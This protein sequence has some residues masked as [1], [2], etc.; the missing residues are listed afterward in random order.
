[1]TDLVTLSDFHLLR[2]WWLLTL[3]PVA[4]TSWYL[5]KVQSPTAKWRP[6]I[7]DHILEHILLPRGR[8]SWFNPVGVY[9]AGLVL[10]IIALSGP[11][12]E[13]QPAPFEED[14]AALVVVLDVSS[15]M[16]LT[17][18]SPT[19]LKRA[20][21][22]VADLVGL[23]GNARTALVVFSG[24]AH[25]AVPLTNDPSLF[26]I[27]L[28]A[29]GSDIMPVEGKVAQNAL[30]LA[31]GLLEKTD[32]SGSILLVTDD[33]PGSLKL[34]VTDRALSHQLLVLG[35]GA[36]VNAGNDKAFVPLNE[37][38]LKRLA[39]TNKGLYQRW[40]MD[41]T[42]IRTIDRRI[43]SHFENSALFVQP[44]VDMGYWLLYPAA[45]LLLLWFRKGWTLQW[46]IAGVV[47]LGLFGG[48]PAEAK[49]FR[50]I[51]LWMTPDQQG[52]H[53][54][55]DGDYSEAAARF[56]NVEW[57][58]LS[59]Y[60][61]EDFETAAELYGRLGTPEGFFSQANALARSQHYLRAVA[62][63]DEAL[64]LDP[65]LEKARHNRQIIQAIIDEINAV[66]AAQVPEPGERSIELGADDP[67]RAEGADRE[68]F[69][70]EEARQI[71]AEELLADEK[72]KEL[73]LRD[74]QSD[75]RRFLSAKFRIQLE[76]QKAATADTEGEE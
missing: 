10:G 71:S 8:F 5:V 76:Q 30:D 24:T 54:F 9:A 13:K 21:M 56:E 33:A 39:R 20:R 51:D 57:R 38:S 34:A 63:Y 14:Q 65:W 59:R 48:T 70:P 53:H 29:I 31:T 1:M 4:M 16:N 50:F 27:F 52:W 17:D 69:T 66:S 28:P 75:P 40:S 73:W 64:R 2:P 6:L 74:V 55:S 45:L 62:A 7:S 36:V 46:V 15:S 67:L 68:Y 43:H 60:L 22:K 61:S 49:E 58:A 41:Q 26:D 12:W 72:L 47:F 23:R 11:S 35:V 37:K 42:D 3:L 32:V 19:R 18:I 44:W 25:I